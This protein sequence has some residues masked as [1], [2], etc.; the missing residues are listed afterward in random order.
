[1]VS[2]SVFHCQFFSL[3][4][5]SCVRI[6]GVNAPSS[7]HRRNASRSLGPPEKPPMSCV[8][9]GWPDRP[10]LIMAGITV[11]PISGREIYLLIMHPVNLHN[12]LDSGV[13]SPRKHHPIAIR[14]YL[15]HH[16]T[17]HSLPLS[18]VEIMIAAGIW[19]VQYSIKRIV[20]REIT[21]QP[22]TPCVSTMLIVQPL[23]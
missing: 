6:N 21:I 1:M 18:W 9:N 3:L 15:I 12:T 14:P 4:L 8:T 16:L 17:G 11:R 13:P 23:A 2:A 19:V 7:V 10:V 20:F 5:P 22:S